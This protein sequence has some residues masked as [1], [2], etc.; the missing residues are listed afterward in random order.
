MSLILIGV[1]LDLLLLFFGGGLVCYV[2]SDPI[3]P[4]PVYSVFTK[5]LTHFSGQFQRVC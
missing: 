1:S 4:E 5:K 2:G 3:Y